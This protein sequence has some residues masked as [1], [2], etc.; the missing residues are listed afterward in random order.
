VFH[1][2]ATNAALAIPTIP[3]VLD[4]PGHL[5]VGSADVERQLVPGE[6]VLAV[7]LVGALGISGVAV[8]GDARSAVDAGAVAHALGGHDRRAGGPLQDAGGLPDGR[9]GGT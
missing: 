5:V 6:R 2:A 3:V 1:A 4:L 7:Q 8:D 9:S